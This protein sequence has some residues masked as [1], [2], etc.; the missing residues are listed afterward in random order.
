MQP[1]FA[2]QRI[3]V[4]MSA[5]EPGSRTTAGTLRTRPEVVG[6]GV[7]RRPVE[8]QLA[9]HNRGRH[10]PGPCGGHA[11]DSRSG[12]GKGGSDQHDSTT[13]AHQI[14]PDEFYG[15]RG[16]VRRRSRARRGPRRVESL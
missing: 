12:A 11:H 8:A 3:V 9:V 10:V 7:A 15:R 13:G 16:D 14:L 4:A 5:V 2:A 1:R 6:G